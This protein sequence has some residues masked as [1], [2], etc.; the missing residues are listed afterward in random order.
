MWVRCQGV[1]NVGKPA[2]EAGKQGSVIGAHAAAQDGEFASGTEVAKCVP[3]GPELANLCFG[4][5]PLLKSRNQPFLWHQ[6]GP[7]AE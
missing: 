4:G 3:H 6:P 7:R 5:R 2:S 1:P